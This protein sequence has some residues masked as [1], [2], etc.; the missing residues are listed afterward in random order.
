ME[1]KNDLMNK[2]VNLCKRRGFVFASSE[3]YG[4]VGGVWD[5]GPL[6]VLLKNNI[7]TLW[8]KRFVQERDDVVGLEGSIIMNPQV[9]K[10]SGHIESFTDPL[11]ECKD[12]H[13]RYRAD[14]MADGRY[15]GN[16]AKD[17]NQCPACGSKKFTEPKNFNMM[18]KTFI[19][20][21]EDSTHQAYL[22]PET[23]QSMFTDFK[24]ILETSRKKIPFGIAQMGKCF[25]NEITYGNYFFRSREFEIAEIEFF[26]KPGEDEK[27]FEKWLAEWKKF[28]LDMGISKNKIRLYEHPKKSLSH[29]S[30]RTVDI[31]YDFPFSTK[32]GESWSE[33]TGLANRTDYDLTQHQKLSGKDLSYFDEEAKKKYIPYVI[34]PTL[35][36]ER[37]MLAILI[38]S[39]KENDKGEVFLDLDPKLAPIKAAILPLVKKDKLPK[40]AKEIYDGLKQNWFVQYDE[41]GSIGRR[42]R[43]QDEI[44]TPFCITVDFETLKDKAV[45]IRDRRT[46]KQERVKIKEISAYLREKL[47]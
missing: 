28:V 25:R 12:C 40:I 1:N 26:V 23:A 42:Y 15:V 14:H 22:R 29:Y 35:G 7:K 32:E 41:S 10:A 46:M 8:W 20:P 43:R 44:G 38:D 5:F 16:N 37:L 39:Y 11:V 19:G 30:K 9:W 17:K 13:A 18:F 24:N 2:V 6:G 21:M 36:I 4:G 31:E 33:L 3:I 45:T 47:A 27:W 34:E